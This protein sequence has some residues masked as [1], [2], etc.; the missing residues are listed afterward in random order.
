MNT[1]P[2]PLFCSHT[3][4]PTF[5]F[6]HILLSL[7]DNSDF[8]GVSNDFMG[9]CD[10]PLKG[11][12]DKQTIRRVLTLKNKNGMLEEQSFGTIDV[13]VKWR[14]NQDLPMNLE[15]AENQEDDDDEDDEDIPDADETEEVGFYICRRNISC[16]PPLLSHSWSPLYVYN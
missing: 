3:N 2:P 13:V 4:N 8:G 1:Y 10:I 6:C 12:F 5:S 15:V 7:H 16:P 14:F 11:L 9:C